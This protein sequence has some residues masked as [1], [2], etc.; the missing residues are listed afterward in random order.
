MHV[1]DDHVDELK[2]AANAV[3]TYDVGLKRLLYWCDVSYLGAHP[4]WKRV[5]L[6]GLNVLNCTEPHQAAGILDHEHNSRQLKAHP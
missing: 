6:S 4:F 5:L 1:C 2:L 3:K